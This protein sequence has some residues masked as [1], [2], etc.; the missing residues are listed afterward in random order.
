M[1]VWYK[2]MTLATDINKYKSS[3]KTE[4]ATKTACI[5]PFF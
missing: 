1:L 4:E 2:I 3:I 5:E